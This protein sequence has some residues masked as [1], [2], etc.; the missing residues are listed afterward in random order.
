MDRLHRSGSESFDSNAPSRLDPAELAERQAS[1]DAW[2]NDLINRADAILMDDSQI[3][4][5]DTSEEHNA[6]AIKSSQQQVQSLGAQVQRLQLQ[7]Q[8]LQSRDQERRLLQAGK[9]EQAKGL[10]LQDAA[11]DVQMQRQMLRAIGNRFEASL[12]AQERQRQKEQERHREGKEE[13]RPSRH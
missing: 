11:V 4:H 6:Q 1:L 12:G 9:E 8:E 3:R 5:D 10:Y 13:R 7:V 2:T